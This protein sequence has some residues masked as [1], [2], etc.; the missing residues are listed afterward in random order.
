MRGEAGDSN[1][2]VPTP[3]PVLYP[4]SKSFMSLKICIY[5]IHDINLHLI[6]EKLP[7]APVYNKEKP[8][9]EKSDVG[10]RQDHYSLDPP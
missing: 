9:T 6:F 3:E 10:E 7:N 2:G 1:L 4:P 5:K 8:T